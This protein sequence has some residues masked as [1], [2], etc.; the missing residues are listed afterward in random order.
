M[1]TL[2]F[3]YPPNPLP[4]GKHQVMLYIY[5]DVS[6]LLIP[7]FFFPKIPYISQIV[8]YFVW[9]FSLNIISCS[10]STQM[11]TCREWD[12][13]L[14]YQSPWKHA[15]GPARQHP[16]SILIT[17]LRVTSK[18]SYVP[19]SLRLLIERDQDTLWEGPSPGHSQAVANGCFCFLRGK[20]G[21]VWG[22]ICPRQV[23]VAGPQRAP[24]GNT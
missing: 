23:N 4:F 21:H 14:K 22:V 3:N 7:F 9:H 16:K 10:L 6:I 2:F 17:G 1:R 18:L 15:R 19:S 5:Q 13:F 20:V 12:H 8:W 11:A 24:G